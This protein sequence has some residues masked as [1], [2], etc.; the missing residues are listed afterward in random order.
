MKIHTALLTV[1]LF[2]VCSSV[3]A[4]W[5][6]LDSG[7]RKVFSD[8]APPPDVAEKNIIKR[9][10]MAVRALPAAATEPNDGASNEQGTSPTASASAPLG[11]VDK[12]LL[13]KKK[14]AADAEEAKRKA[15]L[16]RITKAKIENC[17][18]AKQAK[19][20]LDSGLRISRT[21]ANG[22]REVL[23]DAARASERAR[24]QTV[25]DSECR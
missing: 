4:Q 20:S 24:A 7:G 5:Q 3:F 16:E 23:D 22:E 21:N 8:R 25:I 10:N 14:Q 6:W 18:R 11:G 9:P 2:G 13:A 12:D 17:A 1:A 19:A 15:E